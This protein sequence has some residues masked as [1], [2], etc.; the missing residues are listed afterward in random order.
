MRE[1]RYDIS[2]MALM[3]FLQAKAYGRPLVS[4]PVAMAARF[5]EGALLCRVDSP[6]QGSGDLVGRRRGCGSGARRRGFGCGARWRRCM[7][8]RRRRCTGG[9][10][11]GRMWRRGVTRVGAAEI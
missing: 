3:T 8:W 7:G 10:W 2:E 9:R 5:Q 6:I 11:R 1:L 4:L